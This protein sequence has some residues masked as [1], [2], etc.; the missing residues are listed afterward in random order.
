MCQIRS[1]TADERCASANAD[2]R[3]AYPRPRGDC[4]YQAKTTARR[5]STISGGE[6]RHRR[7]EPTS[8]PECV[9]SSG[10]N[11]LMPAPLADDTRPLG[12]Q[13]VPL[14]TSIAVACAFAMT[15]LMPITRTSW[16][17]LDLLVFRALNGSL[18]LGTWWQKFWAVA[19]W[20]GFD[21]VSGAVMLL[22]VWQ[23]FR[24]RQIHKSAS[25]WISLG[26][27]AAGI[28]V[29]RQVVGETVINHW[30]Q[31]HRPSPTLVLDNAWRLSELVPEI[32][33]KDASQ[34]SFPG[35]HGFVLI[36]ITLYL[37]YIG[38]QKS[39]KRAAV[40]AAI[41]MLPRL[42][43]VHHWLT[44]ILIGSALMALILTSLLLATPIH[45]GLVGR[46]SAWVR[47]RSKPWADENAP[48]SLHLAPGRCPRKG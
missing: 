1:S 17:Q 27:L 12:W 47:S 40:A 24:D 20:R 28:L 5:S 19:N 2:F 43:A 6:L 32:R 46:I 9:V 3:F 41:F 11:E 42:I 18:A 14:A 22:I 7:Q 10:A 38:S 34:W 44:D 21:A 13:P 33:S 35:D 31:Y 36:S 37:S 45:D 4:P 30:L 8:G 26:V 16:D 25:A 39:T 48:K 23:A 29:M 15:W